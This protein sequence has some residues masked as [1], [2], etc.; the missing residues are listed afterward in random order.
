MAQEQFEEL[1]DTFAFLEDWEDRYRHI[2][3]LGKNLDALAPEL[4]VP[5]TKVEGCASQ[6]WL[7][8]T[9]KDGI[10]S[11]HGASD[12]ILVSG[13]IAVLQLLYNDLPKE[14]AQK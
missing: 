8:S 12:A 7:H 11:F 2:I 10:F 1:V 5:A 14:E 6:V 4:R 9:T 13:L 3:D